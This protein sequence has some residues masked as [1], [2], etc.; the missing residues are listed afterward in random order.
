MLGTHLFAS[1]VIKQWSNFTN[2]ASVLLEG[3]VKAVQAIE[4]D[5]VRYHSSILEFSSKLFQPKP[6]L[7]VMSTAL[8][9]AAIH[10]QM[11]RC[12][13]WASQLLQTTHWCLRGRANCQIS[14]EPYGCTWS[15]IKRIAAAD[16]IVLC[17]Q[18]CLGR[19][20][21]KF[22]AK[23]HSTIGRHSASVLP[24]PCTFHFRQGKM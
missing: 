21:H 1:T 23:L 7:G 5:S 15:M 12:C 13:T 24:C 8:F 3:Y 19:I 6:S 16:C 11:H 18:F 22:I 10:Q 4:T 20:L 9:L 2:I 14:Y 17:Q